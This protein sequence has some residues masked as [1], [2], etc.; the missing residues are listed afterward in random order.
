MRQDILYHFFIL[1]SMV[2]P[3]NHIQILHEFILIFA[4]YRTTRTIKFCISKNP[5][6]IFYHCLKSDTDTDGNTCK[7]NNHSCN[8]EYLIFSILCYGRQ[9]TENINCNPYDNCSTANSFPKRNYILFRNTFSMIRMER[10][11]ISTDIGNTDYNTD[12]AY[13][14]RYNEISQFY[15]PNLLIQHSHFRCSEC[16]LK[17]HSD[18]HNADSSGHGCDSG[19]FF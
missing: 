11:Y 19:R 6:I 15:T 9:N 4:V 17:K 12:N 14:E 13:N 1:L 3:E 2:F 8:N 5:F 10:R 16:V 7:H 18:R